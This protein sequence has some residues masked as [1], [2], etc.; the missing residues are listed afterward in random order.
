VAADAERGRE[1]F[2]KHAWSEAYARFAAV[3]GLDGDDLECLAIAAFLTGQDDTCIRA[4]E[5]AH[6]DALR[7]CQPEHAARRAFWLGFIFM[8]GGDLARA[9]GWFAR[10]ERL[11]EDVTEQSVTRGMLLIPDFLYALEGGDFETAATVALGIMR[12]AERTGDADLLAFGLLTRGEAALAFGNASLAMKLFDEAMVSVTTGDLSPICTGILYCAVIDACVDA[13]DMRRA[14]EWTDA[15]SR[16]CDAQP[17]LVPYRGQCLVHRS[18]VLQA[19]GAWADA[20]RAADAARERLSE[21]AHP[22]LGL[23]LYQRGEL[24]R[25]RGELG[26]A[27]R[28]YRAASR[29]GREP[30]PGYALVRLASGNVAAA[31]AA[32]QR[33]LAEE[34]SSRIRTAT[35]AAAVEVLLE[36]GDVNGARRAAE[37]L[38]ALADASS[39]LYLRAVGSYAFGSVLL[40]EGDTPGGLGAARRACNT[41]R[42][43]GMPYD[44]ARARV[45]IAQA[46]RA[47]GDEDGA[48]LELEAACE[49]FAQLGAQTDLGRAQ[50]LHASG[51][52]QPATLTDRECEV[53]RLVATGLTNRAVA[54]ELVLSEHTVARHVQNIFTKIGVSSRAAATAY[55]YAHNIV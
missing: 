24:H 40:A 29:Y 48:S 47:L 9:G 43:L 13:F 25:L 5:R 33:M 16:W 1:A 37:E 2:A 11:V 12:I 19:R 41:W 36:A 7:R 20:A 55:A 27:E 50:A 22:A 15:L 18:Q 10:S 26:E 42:E 28:S 34:R 46:C 14:A 44:A 8:L 54:A 38:E 49:T 52:E 51:R 45:L 17:D 30:E 23:A 53:L 32:I 4:L 3:D 6:A 35:L 21:P 39:A 31:V